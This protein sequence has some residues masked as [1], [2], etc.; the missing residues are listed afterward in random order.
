VRDASTSTSELEAARE[1]I[2]SLGPP[3]EDPVGG[4]GLATWR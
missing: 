1:R 3:P 2:P 4:A